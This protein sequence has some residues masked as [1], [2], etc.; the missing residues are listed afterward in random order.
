VERLRIHFVCGERALHYFQN[1]HGIVTAVA[2]QFDVGV[3]SVSEAVERQRET[4]RAAQK[5]LQEL[6][7][8]KL[9]AEAQQLIAQAE[10]F[11]SIKLV[12]ASFRHRSPQEL[13]T[14]ASQLQNEA[15][16]VALLAAYDGVKLSLTI[17]CA[18]DT[19]VNANDLIRKQLAEIGGRGGG[20]AKLAQGG[21]AASEEQFAAM[22]A[23]TKDYLRAV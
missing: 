9:R 6:L 1:A 21:G 18:A 2:R 7:P 19:G 10:S 5:E 15:S 3:D 4:L 13:R 23:K 11:A 22:F 12:T 14:L 17:A 20:D 16:V 8:L